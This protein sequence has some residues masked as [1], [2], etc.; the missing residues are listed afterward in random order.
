MYDPNALQVG[1]RISG[2]SSAIRESLKSYVFPSNKKLGKLM[3]NQPYS[4]FQ[5]KDFTNRFGC[6][7]K[8]K[9]ST[10]LIDSKDFRKKV[11]IVKSWKKLLIP[12]SVW[13]FN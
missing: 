13:E 3:K 8:T 7:F 11:K 9:L 1:K 5:G 4:V 2:L 10:K 12:T 6:G